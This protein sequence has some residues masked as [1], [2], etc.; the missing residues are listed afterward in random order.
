[1]QTCYQDN[2]LSGKRISYILFCFWLP[3]LVHKLQRCKAVELF[4]EGCSNNVATLSS[5]YILPN[6]QVIV[7]HQLLP[8]KLTPKRKQIIY[9][10]SKCLNHH[11]QRLCKFFCHNFI[12]FFS[13]LHSFCVT[14]QA[15][16]EKKKFLSFNSVFTWNF[17]IILMK[18]S[19][20]VSIYNYGTF[21]RFKF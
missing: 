20:L 8:C 15:N 13:F 3:L 11:N 6:I 5:F 9:R 19:I 17:K 14:I 1:M 12:F 18:F 4:L 21:L 16:E 10:H 2:M 7:V